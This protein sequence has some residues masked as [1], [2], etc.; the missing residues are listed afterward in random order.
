MNAQQ[1]NRLFVDRFPELRDA[2]HEEV[3]WQEGDET[4][5]H[6]VYGDV[7]VPYIEKAIAE[8]A[9]LALS[10]AFNFIEEVLQLHENYSDEVIMFSVLEPL[11]YN[12]QQL[13]CCKKYFGGY[14]EK[15][16]CEIQ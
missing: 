6:I 4:G 14:T 9:D 13:Q 11:I 5:S 3:D 8:K 7:L 16:I 12:D 2:Y 1:L 10:R 15:I